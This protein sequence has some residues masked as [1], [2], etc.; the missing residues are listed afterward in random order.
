[1][2]AKRKR[3]R[4][5]QPTRAV[6]LALKEYRLDGWSNEDPLLVPNQSQLNKLFRM[7][8]EAAKFLQ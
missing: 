4:L 8:V 6:G 7:K 3:L 2:E 1:M 5:D